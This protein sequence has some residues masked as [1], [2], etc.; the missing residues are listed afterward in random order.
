MH[1]AEFRHHITWTSSDLWATDVACNC[2]CWYGTVPEQ[3]IHGLL[4]VDSALKS[5]K[6]WSGRCLS[7]PFAR[8]PIWLRKYI[9]VYLYNWKGEAKRK[10]QGGHTRSEELQGLQSQPSYGSAS[11]TR[12]ANLQKQTRL[13]ALVS[14]PASQLKL[15]GRN[16]KAR[17]CKQRSEQEKQTT[18]ERTRLRKTMRGKLT[19]FALTFLSVL[20]FFSL[21]LSSNETEKRQCAAASLKSPLLRASSA[22]LST[23]N[24]PDYTRFSTHKTTSSICLHCPADVLHSFFDLNTSF[25][26]FFFFPLRAVSVLHLKQWIFGSGTKGQ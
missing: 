12:K 19:E 6:S 11:Q 10:R 5:M 3:F 21:R 17:H 20:S 24:Q 13:T 7:L 4:E 16:Q 25:Y 2:T 26:F 9:R 18:K 1:E 8:S 14:T 23:F 22:S 15:D